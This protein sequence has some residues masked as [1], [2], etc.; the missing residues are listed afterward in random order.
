MGF[1]HGDF[2]E[3]PVKPLSVKMLNIQAGYEKFAVF[4]QYLALSQT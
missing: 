1:S 4:D 2:D 3:I